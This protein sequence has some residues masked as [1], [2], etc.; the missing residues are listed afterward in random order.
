MKILKSRG[1]ASLVLTIAIAFSIVYGSYQSLKRISDATDFVFYYGEAQFAD[2]KSIDS[3]L[4]SRAALAY[5]LTTVAANYLPKDSP[6]IQNVLNARKMLLNV[7]SVSEKARFNKEL[8]STVD[9]LHYLLTTKELSAKD[10]Q[11]VEFIT[12]DFLTCNITITNSTYNGH[13]MSARKEFDK[14]PGKIIA[15]VLHLDPPDYFR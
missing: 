9:S 15:A 1:L 6:E 12:I 14:M 5:N 13:V 2:G 8:T 7:T 4:E 11:S 10:E 3:D